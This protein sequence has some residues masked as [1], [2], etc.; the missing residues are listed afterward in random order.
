MT[1]LGLRKWSSKTYRANGLVQRQILRGCSQGLQRFLNWIEKTYNH[2]EI[3]I[4]E[5]D[6]SV[7]GEDEFR[8]DFYRN[9]IGAVVRAMNEDGI[10][11]VGYMVWGLMDNFEWNGGFRV[12]FGTTYVDYQ[13]DMKRYPKQSARLIVGLFR[14]YMGN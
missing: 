14:K 4:L 13:N 12:R 7:K 5:N 9:H 11:I 1:T 6:T 8:C 10:N 2:S 3:N